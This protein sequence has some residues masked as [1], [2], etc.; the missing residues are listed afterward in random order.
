[1][2]TG[3]SDGVYL[4]S[5]GIPTYGVSGIFGDQDDVRAHGRDER[6]MVK[7]FYDAV[8]FIY[9]VATTLGK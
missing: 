6:V 1:M 3:A 5:K 4:N 2:T 7:S 8:D 9:D